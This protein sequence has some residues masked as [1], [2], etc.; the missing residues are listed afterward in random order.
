M[1]NYQMQNISN[2][3]YQCTP[4]SKCKKCTTTKCKVFQMT[5]INVHQTP[6]IKNVQLPN[7]KYLKWQLSIST[8]CQMSKMHIYSKNLMKSK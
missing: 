8:K 1:Y 4:N 6:N 5:T 2:D 3:N 7:A